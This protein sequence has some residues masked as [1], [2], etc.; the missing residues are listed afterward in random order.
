VEVSGF[1]GFPTLKKMKLLIDYSSGRVDFE[2][3][4]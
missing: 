4:P 1:I 3:K 2:Y